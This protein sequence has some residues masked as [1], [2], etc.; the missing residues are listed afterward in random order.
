MCIYA[1]RRSQSSYDHISDMLP[2]IERYLDD[3]AAAVVLVCEDEKHS[4]DCRNVTKLTR[5]PVFFTFDV[6]I[7]DNGLD[8]N[9]YKID[10]D[11][12]LHYVSLLR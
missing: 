12:A 5:C 3:G 9:I 10:E 4:R 1:V 2:R 6:L 8:G 11:G 7:N